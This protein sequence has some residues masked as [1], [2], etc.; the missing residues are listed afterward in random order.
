QD[1]LSVTMDFAEMPA[2]TDAPSSLSDRSLTQPDTDMHSVIA[3]CR[4]LLL[5]GNK[6]LHDQA[7]AAVSQLSLQISACASISQAKVLLGWAGPGALPCDL[8]AAWPQAI[9]F[10][11][12]LD[13]MDMMTL[14]QQ[15]Q[16][17]PAKAKMAF[18]EISDHVGSDYHISQMGDSSTAHVS[19]KAIHQSLAPAL[20]FELCKVI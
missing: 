1:A 4:V 17:D 3:G 20:V 5:L 11:G 18:V 16:D 13:A 8:P 6:D 7:H 14:R 19:S 10:D 12:N 9:V 15:I 2:V